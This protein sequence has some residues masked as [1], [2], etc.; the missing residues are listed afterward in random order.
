MWCMSGSSRGE[1]YLEY[2][3][4][5]RSNAVHFH[6]ELSQARIQRYLGQDPAGIGLADSEKAILTVLELSFRRDVST[7]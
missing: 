6:L 4:D 1:R 7:I 5:L 2:A 3:G